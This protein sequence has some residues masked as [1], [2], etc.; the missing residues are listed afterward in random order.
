MINSMNSTGNWPML[1]YK[2]LAVNKISEQEWKEK[3]NYADHQ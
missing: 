1:E 2:L 3:V